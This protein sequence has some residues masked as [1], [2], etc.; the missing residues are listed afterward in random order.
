MF[1]HL[2]ARCFP[3][4]VSQILSSSCLQGF[5]RCCIVVF[6]L[7]PICGL[8]IVFQLPPAIP[9]YFGFQLSPSIFHLSPRRF[10]G[11][12]QLSRV[13]LVNV[14]F[15]LSPSLFQLCSLDSLPVVCRLTPTMPSC[16]PDLVPQWFLQCFPLVSKLPPRCGLT[17]VFQLYPLA[18]YL[19]PSLVS[20]S[21]CLP[22]W[23]WCRF[24]WISLVTVLA[25][26]FLFMR[27]SLWL[28]VSALQ[29]PLFTGLSLFVSQSG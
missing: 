15:Q 10:P 16:L 9:I 8:K 1:S 28:M 22:L 3:D 24:L 14:D 21:L 12:F 6:H 23:Y 13:C 19:R 7:S 18:F 27:L 2:S 29:M 5:A 26:G 17:I 11:V 20:A 4:V 25:S